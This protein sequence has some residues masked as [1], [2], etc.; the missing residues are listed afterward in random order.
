[1]AL[2]KIKGIHNT[3]VCATKGEAGEISAPELATSSN[4]GLVREQEL[5][6]AARHM[7]VDELYFLGF[8][9]SGMAGTD[10]NKN[11]FAYANANDSAVVPRLVRFIRTIR[12]QVVVT[13]DPTGGYGH[14]DHIA[15]HRHGVAAFHAAA[16]AS[17]G[18][19]LGEPWQASRLFYPTFRREM[20]TELVE[21]LKSQGIEPPDWGSGETEFQEQ[22]IDAYVDASEVARPKWTA[23]QSHRT[24]FGPANP[25][26]QV[27]EEFAIKILAL[28]TFELAWP[29]TKPD[30][31]YSD[32]FEGL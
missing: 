28:E 9:D 10:E 30:V 13:F 27:P 20:F 32:L 25:F 1:M 3:L 31:Q 18:P 14:P 4:L 26:L 8:R 19:E 6:E 7:G 17:Y 23:F 11:P 16:D 24:Q 21:Q 5:V 29:K 22:A 12:P 15:I 2:N